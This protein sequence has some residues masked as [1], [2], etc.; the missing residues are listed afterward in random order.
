LLGPPQVISMSLG[1]FIDRE[2]E[3]RVQKPSPQQLAGWR[4]ADEQDQAAFEQE[5][6]AA[7]G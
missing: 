7:K 4:R 1:D 5:E 2:R 6:L 3:R